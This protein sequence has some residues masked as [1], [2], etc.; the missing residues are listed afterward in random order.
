[1]KCHWSADNYAPFGYQGRILPTRG[2]WVTVEAD[3]KISGG[4]PKNLKYS[5][6]LDGIFQGYK[7]GYGRDNLKFGVRK[8]YGASHVVLLK[9]FNESRSFFVEKSIT[10]PVANLDL[11][12][13]KKQEASINLPYS[14]SAENFSIIS[15]E[16]NSFSALPY[17]FNVKSLKDL[18]FDWTFANKSY[19]E[20]SLTANIFGLKI[21][22]KKAGDLFEKI[23]KVKATNKQ[24]TDQRAQKTIKLNIYS[25][26]VYWIG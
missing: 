9:V 13:Y 15:N 23:L 14:V 16:E 10:I 4:D 21:T 20:S 18:E 5:W 3:L 7:S 25:Y 24:Q 22:N 26:N 17:F 12:V 19:K 8:F 2:S 11:V 1:M 6:F